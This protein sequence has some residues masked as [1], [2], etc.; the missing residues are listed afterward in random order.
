M[1]GNSLGEIML[2]MVTG[3]VAGL[4]AIGLHESTQSA[5]AMLAK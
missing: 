3:L 4:G 1:N 2:S 5:K